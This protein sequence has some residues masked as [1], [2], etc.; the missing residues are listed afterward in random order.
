MSPNHGIPRDLDFRQNIVVDFDKT[1]D[2]III[3]IPGCPI[4]GTR[5]V[6]W[7]I[8]VL[9]KWILEPVWAHNGV[10]AMGMPKASSV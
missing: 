8:W 3:T 6:D 10:S 5:L 7:P 4:E 2:V 9:V 1:P